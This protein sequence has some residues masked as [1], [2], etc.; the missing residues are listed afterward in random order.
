MNI[1]IA[2]GSGAIGRQLVP[3][4]VQQGHHVVAMTRT[5]LGAARIEA[6]GATPAIGDVFDSVRLAELARQAAPELVIHQLTA[7]GATD[8]DPLAETIR[9]RTEG[10]RNLVAAA[11]QAGARRIITHS[12]SSLK[13]NASKARRCVSTVVQWVITSRSPC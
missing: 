9:V 1:F 8:A 6:M 3:M 2:G 12:I 11:Q 5:P 4:L 10:T 13:A 7:F